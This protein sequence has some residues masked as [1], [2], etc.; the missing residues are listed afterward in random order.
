VGQ[1]HTPQ[2]SQQWHQNRILKILLA[3]GDQQMNAELPRKTPYLQLFGFSILGFAA[4]VLQYHKLPTF[5]QCL[6]QLLGWVD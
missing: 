5:A 3:G 4:M 2:S 1:T 6:L